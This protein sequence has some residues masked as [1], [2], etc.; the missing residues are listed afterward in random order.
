M[1]V[2]GRL[3]PATQRAGS[4]EVVVTRKWSRRRR[5][6]RHAQTTTLKKVEINRSNYGFIH[7]NC[8]QNNRH[9][10]QTN[11]EM[12]KAKVILFETRRKITKIYPK[13]T[14]TNFEAATKHE[15]T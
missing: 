9:N 4:F 2:V 15:I 3:G 7:V 1:D 13:C 11:E 8:S 14:K 6:A 10:L 5:R 12:V